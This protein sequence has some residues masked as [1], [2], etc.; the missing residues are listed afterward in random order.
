MGVQ[1][2]FGQ[3]SLIL[4]TTNLIF[5]KENSV[6]LYYGGIIL[7]LETLSASE[8]FSELLGRRSL[9]CYAE[10]SLHISEQDIWTENARKGIPI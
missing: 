5:S 3:I 10:I 1:I 7:L 2:S 8:E 6:G 4:D 9:Q